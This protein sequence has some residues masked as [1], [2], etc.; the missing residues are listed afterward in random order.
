MAYERVSIWL[1]TAKGENFW[2]VEVRPLAGTGM[3]SV[4]R[5]RFVKQEQA[6]RA[7]LKIR[8]E[9]DSGFIHSEKITLSEV[10]NMFIKDKQGMVSEQTRANY[11]QTYKLYLLPSLGSLP[12]KH[13]HQTHLEEVLRDLASSLRSGTLQT[14]A[15]RTRM[16]FKYAEGKRF[17]SFNPAIHM[18]VPTAMVVTPTQVQEPW[19]AEEARAALAAFK[20]HQLEVF[21]NLL[22]RLGLRKGEAFGLKWGGIDFATKKVSI[23]VG[24]STRR[25]LSGDNRIQ[26]VDSDGQTKSRNARTLLLDPDLL[27]L[28]QREKQNQLAANPEMKHKIEGQYVVSSNGQPLS[29]S[30]VTKSFNEVIERFGLRRVRL[31]DLRATAAVLSLQGGARLEATSQTLGHS[32]TAFTKRVYAKHVPGLSDEFTSVITAVLSSKTDQ[33]K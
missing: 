16:L 6:L 14:V 9:M 2:R 33:N 20:G 25:F 4:Q 26:T 11:F 7:A 18:R 12:I 31:H 19:S 28:L 17:V 5:G 13:V 10:C 3:K 24:R 21:V 29:I 23:S 1:Y 15:T 22:L 32:D 30:R 27:E 8:D